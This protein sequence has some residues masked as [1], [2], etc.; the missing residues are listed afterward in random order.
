MKPRSGLCSRA[1]PGP[2]L[3]VGAGVH[4]GEYPAPRP[5]RMIVKE[6]ARLGGDVAKFVP[7]IVAERLRE[8]FHK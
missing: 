5:R 2:I 8:R 4:G 7:A 1:Q 6:I 3:L